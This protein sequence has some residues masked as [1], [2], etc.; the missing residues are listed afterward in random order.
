MAYFLHETLTDKYPPARLRSLLEHHRLECRGP[1]HHHLL[2]GGVG[3]DLGLHLRQ[4]RLGLQSLAQDQPLPR[5]HR[6]L[7][8][9]PE[10]GHAFADLSAFAVK[11]PVKAL[12]LQ[13]G[14]EIVVKDFLVHFLQT[15]QVSVVAGQLFQD[16]L[17]AT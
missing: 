11:H 16:Q 8:A 3:S 2:K 4:V 12:L 1:S 9:S 7:G 15:Y 5:F 10:T 13:Q 14:L 6:E 17:Y